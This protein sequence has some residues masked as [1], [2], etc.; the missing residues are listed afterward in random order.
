MYPVVSNILC[1]MLRYFSSLKLILNVKLRHTT[2]YSH[3]GDGWI[4]LISKN[5][6]AESVYNSMMSVQPS[7]C[8]LR[9]NFTRQDAYQCC[10]PWDFIPRSWDFFGT[11]GF[12][13]DFYFK[14]K[15]LGFFWGFFRIQRK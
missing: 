9:L 8:N 10:Q 15:A 2:M 5:G 7:V 11:L 4:L 6:N 1:L 13:W 3:G 12:S 14:N